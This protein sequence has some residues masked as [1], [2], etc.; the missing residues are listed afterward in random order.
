MPRPK[1]H[2]KGKVSFILK[3][4]RHLPFL[5]LSFKK[6]NDEL[7]EHVPFVLWLIKRII[8]PI[9]P[10]LVLINIFLRIELVPAFLLG[11]I[12]FIYGNFAPDFDILMKY[13]E[14]KNS[15]T[16]K[17][18]FILYLGPLY[19]YYYI[20]EF[21]RPVYTNVKRE[22]HSMKYAAYYFLFVFLIGLLIFNPAE[23]YKTLIFSFLGIAGY[24]V[25]LLIDKKL[26]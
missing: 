20:F 3:F 16:Y 22:F 10:L 14:K 19:L 24:L 26:G 1:K 6:L 4:P 23:I 21:S 9:L 25:H 5:K 12:P 17:K 7:K 11:L 13:S 15:P 8:I 18:L 2:I